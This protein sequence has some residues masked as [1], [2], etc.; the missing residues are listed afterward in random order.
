MAAGK[1]NITI[2]QG[3]DFS[4]QLTVKESGSAKNLTGYN[5]RAQLRP[6]QTSST[7]SATFTT[8]ITNASGGVMTMSL[9]YGTTAN[10][11]GGKYYYDLEI[12]TGS[13]VQR[14][15]QGQA[16]VRTNVTT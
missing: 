8:T 7:L 1:Y 5:A 12:Y 15:I 9:P 4:I 16:T 2:D 3:S 10:L 6:T 14:L 13:A 11:D